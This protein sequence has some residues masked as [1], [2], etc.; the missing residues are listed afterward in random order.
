[1]ADNAG[2]RANWQIISVRKTMFLE[3][4]DSPIEPQ[5]RKGVEKSR[6]PIHSRSD[7]ARLSLQARMAKPPANEAKM[8]I[9]AP[10]P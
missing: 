9:K 2:G 1:M 3:A 8:N 4:G 7:Q 6:L 5:G 10:I